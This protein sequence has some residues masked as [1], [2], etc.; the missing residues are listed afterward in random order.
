MKY[1]F[2]ALLLL[3]LPVWLPAQQHSLYADLGVPAG[4]SATYNYKVTKN[5][6]AGGGVQVQSF[7]LP[8]TDKARLI[9]AIFADVHLTAW[10]TK[11]N[12]LISFLDLGIN[13]HRQDQSYHRG[14]NLVY[15]IP[16]NNGFY[17][18]LGLGYFRRITKRGGGAYLALKL[19]LNWYNF[20]EYSIV[21][22]YEDRSTLSGTGRP[23]LVIGFKF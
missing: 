23:A 16:H 4:L 6:G 9:P 20:K 19:G 18:G 3:L 22:D 21:T 1:L 13:L 5:L 7:Y 10:A 15:N 17:S 14:S 2:T 12:R 8:F 11:R